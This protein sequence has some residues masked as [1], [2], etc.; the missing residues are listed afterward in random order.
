MPDA[1]FT[2]RLDDGL[3]TEFAE[4]AKAQERTAAQLLRVL[5]RAEVGR[6]REMAEHD[7]WFRAEVR[8]SLREADDPNLARIPHEEVRATLRRERARPGARP[9]DEPS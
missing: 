5:M 1:T 6:Q 2:F 9:D 7:I 3:K 8:Q 4:V